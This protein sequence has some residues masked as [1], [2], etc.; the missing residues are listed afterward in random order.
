MLERVDVISIQCDVEARGR[1][2]C[3]DDVVVKNEVDV[4]GSP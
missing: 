3:T 1:G 2:R 4:Y